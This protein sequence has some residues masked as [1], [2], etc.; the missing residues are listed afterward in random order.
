MGGFPQLRPIVSADSMLHCGQNRYLVLSRQY[1]YL[2]F[3]VPEQPAVPLGES[4]QVDALPLHELH[5]ILPHLVHSLILLCD[6]RWL[7]A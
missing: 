5:S 3:S 6:L 4:L 7:Q 1:N 2:R